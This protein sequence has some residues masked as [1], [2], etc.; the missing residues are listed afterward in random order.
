MHNFLLKCDI[1]WRGKWLHINFYS[2]LVKQFPLYMKKKKYSELVGHEMY[3][4]LHIVAAHNF[5][6]Y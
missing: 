3:L 2:N 6:D 5:C 4:R 1:F